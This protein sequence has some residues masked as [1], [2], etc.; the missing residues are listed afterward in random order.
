MFFLS[1]VE[2]EEEGRK[3][4]LSWIHPSLHLL[5]LL[6]YL[7]L[8]HDHTPCLY[9]T[10]YT[11]VKCVSG[12]NEEGTLEKKVDRKF[13][14]GHDSRLTA[15]TMLGAGMKRRRRRRRGLEESP[16]LP[17]ERKLISANQPNSYQTTCLLS[18]SPPLS[19]SPQQAPPPPRLMKGWLPSPAPKTLPLILG[20]EER[21]GGGCPE[22]V[23]PIT[24][25]IRGR[26]RCDGGGELTNWTDGQL[27][28]REILKSKISDI[29]Y[30]GCLVLCRYVWRYWPPAA[31]KSPFT[32]ASIKPLFCTVFVVL[33]QICFCPMQYNVLWCPFFVSPK[34]EPCVVCVPSRVVPG[35]TVHRAKVYSWER[36][37]GEKAVNLIRNNTA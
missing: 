15:T 11:V 34:T 36:G 13:T 37:E 16:Q 33:S 21:E 19:F 1:A 32:P 22:S 31:L 28:G 18:W 23:E 20:K 17:Q 9:C 10:V 29:P 35:S 3:D 14:L 24:F 8:Q 25:R 27:L 2:E 6:G 26:H 30:T 4:Y 12:E 7:V 5:L